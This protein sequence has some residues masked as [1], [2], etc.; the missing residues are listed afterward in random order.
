MVKHTQTIRRLEPTNRLNVFDHFWGLA[1]EPIHVKGF[2]M[3]SG[4]S[5]RDQW[6]EMG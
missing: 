2:L 3:F 5:E 4:S 6:H 1:V